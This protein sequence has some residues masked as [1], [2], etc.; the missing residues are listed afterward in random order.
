MNEL[1]GVK[2][3]VGVFSAAVMTGAMLTSFYQ[4]TTKFPMQWPIS[5]NVTAQFAQKQA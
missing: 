2:A 5:V 4:S 3:V 1:F